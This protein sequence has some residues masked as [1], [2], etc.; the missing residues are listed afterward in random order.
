MGVDWKRGWSGVGVEGED[1]D[2]ESE[3]GGILY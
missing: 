2:R 1:R 3:G